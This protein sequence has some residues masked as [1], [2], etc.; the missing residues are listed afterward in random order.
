MRNL[1]IDMLLVF[2]III[3]STNF[4]IKNLTFYE[5]G[6]FFDVSNLYITEVNDGIEYV[7]S[8]NNLT[9]KELVVEILD[10]VPKELKMG[11]KQIFLYQ[12]SN[13]NVAGVAKDEQNELYNLE[14]YDKETQKYIVYHEIAHLWGR[15]LMQYKMLDYHYTDYA[16][17]V[18]KDNNYISN[19]SK[20]YNV[21]KNN[22]SED[23]ADSVA[24]YLINNKKLSEK[25][26]NRQAYI[27]QMLDIS[28]GGLYET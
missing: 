13:D 25:Y 3:G 7:Y 10:E 6:S 20:K 19:Y 16:E 12:S 24:K 23:F 1:I 8:R 5:L 4:D 22:Y 21:E 14:Q 11:T 18:R 9:S 27:E 15:K 26:S 17:A 2:Q 28:E